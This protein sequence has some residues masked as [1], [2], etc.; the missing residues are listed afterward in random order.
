[1]SSLFPP[2]LCPLITNY[3]VTFYSLLG[4]LAA[5]ISFPVFVVLFLCAVNNTVSIGAAIIIALVLLIFYVIMFYSIYLIIGSYFDQVDLSK[6]ID[7]NSCT[8]KS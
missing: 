8:K 1:M 2:E 5:L 3:K 4:I 7:V 6:L